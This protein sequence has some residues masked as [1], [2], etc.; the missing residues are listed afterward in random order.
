MRHKIAS[1]DITNYQL[2][3]FIAKTKK[4]ILLSTGAA[5]IEEIGQA[6]DLIQK[7]NSDITLMHC[8][9]RYP[10]QIEFAAL[11]RITILRQQFPTLSIGYSDHTAPSDF[12]LV[13]LTAWLL[14]ARVIEK[15]FTL[16]KNLPGNDHYHAFDPIDLEKFLTLAKQV[17]V[18][19]NFNEV[20]YISSQI[21][22]REQARRGIYFKRNIQAGSKVTNEDLISL[23][24]VGQVPSNLFFE[25]VGSKLNKDV[26]AY[27]QP[28]PDTLQ[29][30]C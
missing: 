3:E 26:S 8:V 25:I 9:L 23:R 19:R 29:S 5:T 22:A 27:S 28:T 6:V 16:D 14:G 13:Q 12:P 17:V 2:I 4:P 21:S 20:D 11:D 18:S 10:T 15:H 1:A 30:Q 24:P 7:F